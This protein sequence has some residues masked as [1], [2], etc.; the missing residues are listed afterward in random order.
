MRAGRAAGAVLV[1]SMG[2]AGA[3]QAAQPAVGLGTGEPF[4]VLAGS[5]IT[6]TGPST[7]AGDLGLSPGTA[8]AGFGGAG[9]G[10]VGGDTHVADAVALQAKSDLDVAYGDAAGRTPAAAIPADL[11]AAG[12]LTPGVYRAS[13]QLQLTGSVTLDAQGDPSAVFVFQVGSAL[14]TAAGSVVRLVDGAQA[15]NVF[16]QIGSSATLGSSSEFSGTLMADQ[17]ISVLDSVT[18]HGRLLARV[19]AVS[20]ID[21]TIVRPACATSPTP[22]GSAATPTAPTAAA[23]PVTPGAT[24]EAGDATSQRPTSSQA[25]TTPARV[26]APAL[27]VV[28]RG[29][30][31]THATVTGVLI[32]TVTVWV[33]GRRVAVDAAGPFRVPIAVPA[34]DHTI[35]ARVT[36][37]DSRAPVLLRRRFHTR[38][39][40][41]RQVTRPGH[42]LARPPKTSGGFTG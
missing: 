26:P 16:W 1:T 17:S 21:D 27:A 5:T 4:A 31:R 25:Q 6:N 23:A 32:A 20:L 35:T 38:R 2:F 19:G 30:G 18:V 22:T 28:D 37:K 9:D 14:T 15:C 36:F 33:D 11:A 29:A 34:G 24:Q 41:P 13:S 7:V 40:R 10:T 42:A 3:A 12:V 8:V 39:P